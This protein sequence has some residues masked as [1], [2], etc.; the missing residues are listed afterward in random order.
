MKKG[1][2]ATS[3][4]NFNTLAQS[5]TADFGGATHLPEKIV[6]GE[7]SEIGDKTVWKGRAKRK[8]ISQVFNLGLIVSVE[9]KGEPERKQAYWNAYHCQNR[10]VSYE[11]RIYGKYCKSRS[12]TLCCSIRKAEII[13]RYLPVIKAWEDPFFVTLTVRAVPARKLGLWFKGFKIAFKRICEKYKK[14]NQRGTGPKLVGIKSLECNFNPKEKTYNPHLHLIVP[15]EAIADVLIME[16]LKIWTKKEALRI[17]QHKERVRDV[18]KNLVEVIKYGAKVF[19]DP[20]IKQKGMYP[21]IIYTAATDTI[22]KAMKP[23]RIFER[24]GFNLPQSKKEGKVKVVP[25]LQCQDLV[26][27]IEVFDWVNAK[28]GERVTGYTPTAQL[29]GL[30]HEN[31]DTDL[32]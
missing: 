28:T 31:I 32:Q 18:E 11:G 5:G 17:G 26:F 23:Y 24:F 29:Y 4:E 7:G 9:K 30:L 20:D 3:R 15:N 2:S 10:L 22:L 21:P 27:A 6:Y 13:N 19:T 1:N 25:E 14:R 16:W 12:C 8:T